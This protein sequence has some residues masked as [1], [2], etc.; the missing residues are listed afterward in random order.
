MHPAAAIAVRLA[1][2]AL[3]LLSGGAA[4]AHQFWYEKAGNGLTFRYGELDKNMHEVTPGGLD[5]MVK[6]ETTWYT[7]KGEQKIELIK[8]EDRLDLPAGVRPG[9]ADS[10]VSVDREYPM[11]DTARDGKSLHT[12]WVPATRWV[13][14]FSARKPVLTLDI[15]PTGKR[16]GNAAEFRATYLGE[17][18]VGEE[19]QVAV[20]SGWVK[21]YVTD[22]DG[23]FLAA[24]PWRGDYSVNIYFVDDVEG[25]RKLKGK[26]DEPYQ[27]EGYNMTL[28]FQVADGLKPLPVAEKTLPAS[29]LKAM[30][31]TPPKH[32]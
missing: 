24:L 29:V 18:L 5:R 7:P 19:I 12:Y 4:D 28:S 32:H 20:P 3:L 27:L 15:V 30:G 22:I 26:P 10:I 6:L 14:D 1:I 25:V 11:F 17:P 13:G 21:K 16:E 9:A 31:I 2:P 23:R 8:H